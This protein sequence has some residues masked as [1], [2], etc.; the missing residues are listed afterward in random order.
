M[1]CKASRSIKWH[2]RVAGRARF[3]TATIG[4]PDSRER[5]LDLVVCSAKRGKQLGQN[6]QRAFAEKCAR[7]KDY[8]SVN[9]HTQLQ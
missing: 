2:V 8:T 7:L 4:L 3:P 6:S 5:A 1:S 9:C